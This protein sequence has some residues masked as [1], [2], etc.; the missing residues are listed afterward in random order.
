MKQSKA[1]LHKDNNSFS[2][3]VCNLIISGR[4]ERSSSNFFLQSMRFISR[5]AICLTFYAPPQSP[6]MLVLL[7]L[8]QAAHLYKC[9]LHFYLA[10]KARVKMNAIHT[11]DAEDCVGWHAS[12][13]SHGDLAAPLA[14]F[15]S[16][17]SG[18]VVCAPTTGGSAY[19]IRP[20]QGCWKVEIL[21]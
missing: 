13:M 19:L 6:P 12:A 9:L 1:L 7:F 14:R 3:N 15:P 10:K 21:H 4:V 17:Q 16:L 11:L 18:T 2:S 20:M 8:N 5:I